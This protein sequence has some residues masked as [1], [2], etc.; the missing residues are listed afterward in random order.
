MTQTPAGAEAVIAR[1]IEQGRGLELADLVIKGARV[2]DI[3]TTK[4]FEGDVA[5]CG[6]TIVGVFEAYEGVETIDGRGLTVVPGFIDA[7]LHI[8]SSLLAPPEFERCVLP[9]GV[10]TA[11][12]DPH[13]IVNVLGTHGIDYALACAETAVMDIRVNLS[14][15]VPA[16]PLETS[17]ARLEVEDL[18]PYRGHPKVIGLAEFMNFPGVLARDP[19]CL[20][21]LAAFQSGHIDGH[22]PLVR[23]K[24]LNGYLSAGIRTDHEANNYEEA[25]EKLR[26]GMSVLIRESSIAKDLHALWPLITPETSAFLGFCTDDR[27]PVE[28][29]EE[30][31][32]DHMIR[33]T[34][35]QGV[36]P[37]HVY[38]VASWSAA[39]VFGL[40]DRGVVAPGRRADLVLLSDFETCRIKTVI[41][42]GKIVGPQTFEGRQVPQPVGLESMKAEPV[43]AA[44]LAVKGEAGPRAVIGVVPGKI[45]TERLEIE[46]QASG[47]GVAPDLSQDALGVA[48]VARH[49]VNRNIGRGF[50]KGFGLREGAIASSV[51]HDSHN[52]CVVGTDASEMAAAAN[53]VIEL[54]GGF[55]VTAGGAVKAELA[56]PLAGLMSLEPHEAV[57]ESLLKLRAA[58]KA[59]GCPL[60]EPFLQVA[61][62]PLAVIPHLKITDFGM[63]DVDRFELEPV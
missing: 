32:I 47:G 10:T 30:G 33:W 57:R 25:F 54:G 58:A 50:V 55:V 7:H 23:G 26:K 3:V 41:A 61:F 29:A 62:L 36:D 44:D 13:E 46:L 37:A 59:L 8:E 22:A 49:G 2:L 39:N 19:G 9:H 45:V 28:I 31:H 35:A 21:K 52:I 51:G 18:E 20:A 43:E 34:I 17:G 42:G 48:V 38:R 60:A 12:W 56:L 4:F 6:D 24:D 40:R 1:R 16:S 15:C 63:V 11:I 5:I 14:S 27:N 53:R